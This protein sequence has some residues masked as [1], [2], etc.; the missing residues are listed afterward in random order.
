MKAVV[1]KLSLLF[2]IFLLVACTSLTL[3]SEKTC[4]EL[5]LNFTGVNSKQILCT[6]KL[7]KESYNF[8]KISK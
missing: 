1:S 4:Y 5:I 8:R 2:I 7:L 3:K 6:T